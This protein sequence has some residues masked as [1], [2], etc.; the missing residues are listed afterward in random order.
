MSVDEST[1]TNLLKICD[2]LIGEYYGSLQTAHNLETDSNDL[3]RR[4]L[5]FYGVVPVTVS[6]I[7][8]EL[9]PY[10]GKK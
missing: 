7:L 6:I 1:T 9:R 3:D 8:R 2:K 4:L 10:R 5:D